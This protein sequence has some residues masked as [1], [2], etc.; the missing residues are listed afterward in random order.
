MN[1]NVEDLNDLEP[2]KSGILVNFLLFWAVAHISR[3]NC[4]ELAGDRPRQPVCEIFAIK[5]RF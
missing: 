4:T 3:V 5:C 2:P 1:V